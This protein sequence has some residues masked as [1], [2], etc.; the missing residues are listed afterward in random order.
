MCVCVYFGVGVTIIR[1]G[2]RYGGEK[3]VVHSERSFTQ[4]TVTPS[5]IAEGQQKKKR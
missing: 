3:D 5:F 2:N 1:N 4:G